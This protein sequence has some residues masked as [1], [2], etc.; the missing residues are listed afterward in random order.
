MRMLRKRSSLSLSLYLSA[1][2]YANKVNATFLLPLR[3]EAFDGQNPCLLGLREGIEVD[4]CSRLEV[5]RLDVHNA[6][7]DATS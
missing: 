2:Y 5:L 4:C 6:L 7:S 1:P 3:K